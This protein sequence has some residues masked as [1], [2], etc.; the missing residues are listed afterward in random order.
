MVLA[1]FERLLAP[2]GFKLQARRLESTLAP[3]LE[4]LS[5]PR[6]QVFVTDAHAPRQA[7]EVLVAGI[8]QRYPHARQVVVAEK[9]SEVLAFPLLRLGAKGLLSYTEARQKLA[10]ALRV[11]AAGGFWVPRD[12]LSRFIDSI[13]GVMR[14]AHPRQ[15]PGNLSHREREVLDALLENLANKEI[16]DK[17][18][19]SERTVK[20]H[21]SS[22]LE[23]FSVRRRIDLIL[24]CFQDRSAVP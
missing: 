12:L 19:I 2:A 20:F 6:A 23:K 3:G 21:V 7:T 24:L 17:L 11:V 4:R 8:Q 22:L 14:G 10:E 5:L 13:L 16:A 1:E 9:F 15:S 18:H